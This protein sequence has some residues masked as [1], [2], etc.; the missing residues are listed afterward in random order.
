MVILDAEVATFDRQ[1]DSL[2]APAVPRTIALLGISTGYAG[3][4]LVTARQNLDRLQSEAA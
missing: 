1:L 2:V 3:Q 4:L